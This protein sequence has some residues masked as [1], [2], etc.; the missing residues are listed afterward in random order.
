MGIWRGIR[1]RLS[2]LFP[3][4]GGF[5]SSLMSD[6]I[7]HFG[8]RVAEKGFGGKGKKNAPESFGEV[9]AD[10]VF[11]HFA[12]EM[13][14][15]AFVLM[16]TKR[17]SKKKW[18]RML[19][20]FGHFGAE[21][22]DKMEVVIGR[23][24]RA[25]ENGI[26][27]IV[28]ESYQT[29]GGQPRTRSRAQ[30]AGDPLDLFFWALNRIFNESATDEE[31]KTALELFHQAPWHEK[32]VE[33]LAEFWDWLSGK[34]AKRPSLRKLLCLLT[35]TK[36]R[37]VFVPT[38]AGSAFRWRMETKKEVTKRA[39]KRVFLFAFTLIALVFVL[40]CLLLAVCLA[41]ALVAVPVF[42]Y[43]LVFGPAAGH[44][45]VG[46]TIASMTAILVG[47]AVLPAVPIFL[48]R[49]IIKKF[50]WSGYF[51][52]LLYSFVLGVGVRVVDS[53]CDLSQ[54][55]R[56][57]LMFVFGVLMLYV[58]TGYWWLARV[59]IAKK[60]QEGDE[61]ITFI[62]RP[63]GLGLLATAAS[64]MI[65][66]SLVGMTSITFFLPNHPNTPI[67]W[68]TSIWE[69][70]HQFAGYFNPDAAINTLTGRGKECRPVVSARVVDD[71]GVVTTVS[72]VW[73]FG[74][75]VG[76]PSAAM[77]Y[78]CDPENP[79]LEP[80]TGLQ[81]IPMTGQDKMLYFQWKAEQEAKEKSPASAVATAETS[82]TPATQMVPAATVA[83]AADIPPTGPSPT[84]GEWCYVWRDRSGKSD[85]L[86]LE[87]LE[88]NSSV[89]RAFVR[90]QSNTQR[91]GSFVTHWD[92]RIGK[93]VGPFS[94]TG[95]VTGSVT[96]PRVPSNGVLHGAY[97]KKG[98]DGEIYIFPGEC[99]N[100][101]AKYL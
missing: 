101:V 56:L 37:K 48:A 34:T 92:T 5:G 41:V 26:T 79:G 38:K 87:T 57:A 54:Y 15:E 6:F 19:Q 2:K 22:Q 3:S 85:W 71:D 21:W 17:F 25:C 94:Q 72:D 10:F 75:P 59:T 61:N 65:V 78:R 52:M 98:E 4:V 44:A 14:I 60:K 82:P 95:T 53:V 35:F 49:R 31:I 47:L 69:K 83:P 9:A 74:V 100:E 1:R 8:I 63:V 96:L 33:K 18:Q 7:A 58:A 81:G 29:P 67:S 73:P 39:W 28:L 99:I 84:E 55:P 90:D 62:Q 42:L 43:K 36:P 88:Y 86:R 46:A 16:C 66:V 24:W 77:K 97:S 13:P 27:Y 76:F 51:L 93:Y 45:G 80:L 89:F 70:G 20:F 12:G 50:S 91:R 68:T 23:I 30:Q 11:K 64:V 32:L 40:T